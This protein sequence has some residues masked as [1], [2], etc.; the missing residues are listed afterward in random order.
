MKCMHKDFERSP[1]YKT[2]KNYIKPIVSYYLK[3]LFH[4]LIVLQGIMTILFLIMYFQ[5]ITNQNITNFYFYLSI[6]V[7]IIYGI[8]I[9][10]NHFLEFL[11]F[12][13]DFHI[14]SISIYLFIPTFKIS[15][16]SLRSWGVVLL[17]LKQDFPFKN[18][19]R[20]VLIFLKK[21]GCE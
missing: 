8:M 21:S 14:Q 19:L 2:G 12:Y 15:S 11:V 5:S 9:L 10:G 4:Y 20:S 16:I 1:A 3:R 17:I 18:F 13:Y 7:F 6:F